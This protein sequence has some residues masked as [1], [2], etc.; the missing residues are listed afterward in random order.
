M[1]SLR[2]GRRF[3]EGDRR[4]QRR[5]ANLIVLP[6]QDG[7]SGGDVCAGGAAV[8]RRRSC[9][10]RAAGPVP[11]L[12]FDTAVR[13]DNCIRG[14]SRTGS[15][16]RSI[17]GAARSCRAMRRPRSLGA[18]AHRWT[19]AVFA[20]ALLRDVGSEPSDGC[21]A[22]V[23]GWVPGRR[24]GLAGRTSRTGRR[25]ARR[26]GGRRSVQRD[27]RTGGARRDRGARR[28]R[29][30]CRRAQTE[31]RSPAGGGDVENR[32][33]APEADGP[34][35]S[36]VSTRRVP[37]DRGASWRGCGR[38]RRRNLPVNVRGALVH[39]VEDGLLL[40]SPGIFRAFIRRDGAG[41]M[42]PATPPSGCSARSCGPA[43]TC[44]P[45]AA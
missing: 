42:N 7:F 22:N 23:R 15:C 16:A 30:R 26:A 24:P 29:R 35:F 34:E 21:G 11:G 2:N 45:T 9:G 43:G 17:T 12:R 39:G 14:G 32:R 5:T 8:D 28:A 18:L 38:D 25:T 31:P 41:A 40:A 10:V 33:H 44:G 4:S 20:A 37:S 6:R 3:S 13:A 1:V 27:C 36:M 19:Y